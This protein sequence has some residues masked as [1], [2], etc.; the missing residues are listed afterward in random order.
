MIKNNELIQDKTER[1][2]CNQNRW[3]KYKTN[4]KMVGLNLT[5]SKITLNINGSKK[6]TEKQIVK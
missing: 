3:D 1:K 2:N 4:S 6:S 5:I